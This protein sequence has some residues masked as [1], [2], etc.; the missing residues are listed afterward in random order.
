[1][2]EHIKKCENRFIDYKKYKWA[3]V[4]PDEMED[5]I[6]KLM[7][8][9]KE[10]R[11]IDKRSNVF[12]GINDDLKKWKTFIPLLNDLKDPAMNTSDSRHWKEVKAVVK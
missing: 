12:M 11:G 9:L 5:E 1:M 7:K 10:M 6:N 2:W 4:N 3:E 8:F